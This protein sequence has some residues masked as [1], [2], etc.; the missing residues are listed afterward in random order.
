MAQSAAGVRR[1]VTYGGPVGFVLLS[2]L[3]HATVLLLPAGR[4]EITQRVVPALPP[5]ILATKQLPLMVQGFGPRRV[6]D[7]LPRIEDVVPAEASLHVP[8]SAELGA[9]VEPEAVPGMLP[10]PEYYPAS[11]LTIPPGLHTLGAI[12]P[13]G[14]ERMAGG[15]RVVLELYLAASGSVD[16]WEL[17]EE[18]APPAFREH[19]LKTFLSARYTPGMLLGRPVRS[20]LKVEATL[21]PA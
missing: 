3:L 21:A 6:L 16:R 17:L 12:E 4:A 11:A 10:E 13:D 19:V 2:V 7:P 20:R 5:A 9:E 14:Y 1:A 15:G 18:S 8:R